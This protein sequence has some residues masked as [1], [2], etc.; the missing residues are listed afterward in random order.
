MTTPAVLLRVGE[1][2]AQRRTIRVYVDDADPDTGKVWLRRID[3][4]PVKDL[5]TISG[6]GT[7][8]PT[9][10]LPPEWGRELTEEVT[11]SV[12]GTWERW[13]WPPRNLCTS[14]V[15]IDK[16][17]LRATASP[18]SEAVGFWGLDSSVH[19]DWVATVYMVGR[20]RLVNTVPHEVEPRVRASWAY[21]DWL[22]EN[23]ADLLGVDARRKLVD[24]AKRT[25]K[26]CNRLLGSS[27]I[28]EGN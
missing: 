4:A 24:V 17:L 21:R 19:E 10:V 16:R 18:G 27:H 6:L 5:G 13:Q 25:A 28:R 8:D 3:P 2:A 12:I 20:I 14:E 1:V 26:R 9:A 15:E 11:S 23:D 22:G 7:P